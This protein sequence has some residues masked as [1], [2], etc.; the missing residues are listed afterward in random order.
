MDIA[1][2]IAITC[3]DQSIDSCHNQRCL[4]VHSVCA[5][6]ETTTAE[7]I[8]AGLGS[9]WRL[10]LRHGRHQ[11]QLARKHTHGFIIDLQIVPWVQWSPDVIKRLRKLP[12]RT[13]SRSDG[14]GAHK[15][16]VL[17]VRLRQPEPRW[18]TV[19][20][21]NMSFKIDP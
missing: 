21:R 11:R 18:R 6:A 8:K 13:S 9:R 4:G 5:H 3:S 19:I 20:T 12:V 1:T 15:I 14:S 17:L 7:T 2:D 16:G 10:S